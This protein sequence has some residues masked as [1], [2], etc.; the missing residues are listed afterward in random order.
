MKDI[1]IEALRRIREHATHLLTPED[2]LRLRVSDMCDGV[3]VEHL[4]PL[5]LKS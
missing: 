4:T 2:R 5:M 1:S 3:S